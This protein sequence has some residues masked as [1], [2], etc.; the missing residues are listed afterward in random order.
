MKPNLGQL[1][2]SNREEQEAKSKYRKTVLMDVKR[3][4]NERLIEDFAITLRRLREDT[5]LAIDNLRPLPKRRIDEKFVMPMQVK[6][7]D[8]ENILETAV[9][10]VWQWNKDWAKDNGLAL[11]IVYEK[12]DNA[13]FS[14]YTMY[15]DVAE[16][17]KK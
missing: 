13:V 1:L 14:W 10:P 4:H 15:F 9:V 6:K 7:K 2:K 17:G 8:F 11:N 5:I 3:L 12:C 16:E